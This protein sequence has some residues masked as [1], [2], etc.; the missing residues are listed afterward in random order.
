MISAKGNSGR[1]KAPQPKAVMVHKGIKGLVAS[2][3]GTKKSV[4]LKKIRP[5]KKE[6]AKIPQDAMKKV[7][8]M[9]VGVAGSP[10]KISKGSVSLNSPI[11]PEGGISRDA[12][13]VIKPGTN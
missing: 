5:E 10:K 1:E 3:P 9:K 12:A 11:R 7:P 2:G 8:T 13:K 6:G 4:D